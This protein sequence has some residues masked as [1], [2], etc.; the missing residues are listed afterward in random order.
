MHFL[1]ITALCSSLFVNSFKS[2]W[3][4]NML[5]ECLYIHLIILFIYVMGINFHGLWKIWCLKICHFLVTIQFQNKLV[6][7][8]NQYEGDIFGFF[9]YQLFTF[10]RLNLL[11]YIGIPIPLTTIFCFILYCVNVINSQLFPWLRKS[12]P[13]PC[14]SYK[15]SRETYFP[16]IVFQ[17]QA[18]WLSKRK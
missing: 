8:D 2:S 12:K 15:K 17:K 4:I 3:K 7:W 16:F 1:Y 9:F 11:Q 6:Y 10:L 13:Y 14:K 18:Q 5:L